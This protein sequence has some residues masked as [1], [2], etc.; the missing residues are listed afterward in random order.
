MDRGI[1]MIF[2]AVTWVMLVLASCTTA[3]L[4]AGDLSP[5]LPADTHFV[6]TA[7][8]M[9]VL[10][11]AWANSSL[12]KLIQGADMQP[13]RAALDADNVA[14]LIRLRPWF[15]WD[16]AELAEVPDQVT[17]GIFPSAIP[18]AA[19]PAPAKAP[20]AK[21]PPAKGAAPAAPTQQAE[22][23]CLIAKGKDP[24]AAAACRTAGEAYFKNLGIA[25]V[26]KQAGK[27]AVT[28]YTFKPKVGADYT[29]V[30][31]ETPQYLGAAT[32]LRGAELVLAKLA[33]APAANPAP[34]KGLASF[35]LEPLPLFKLLSKPPAKGKRNMVRFFERQGGGEIELVSG[36]LELPEKG[37]LELALQGEL[38]GNFPLPKGLGILDYKLGAPAN[39]DDYFGKT[40]H[41]VRHWR[42]DFPKAMKSLGNL[43]DEWTEPGPS[44]EGV[45]D[46]LLDGLRDDP[47]GQKID[48]RKDLFAQLGP[49]VTELKIDDPAAKVPPVQYKLD[50]IECIDAVKAEATLK[51]YWDDP[52]VMQDVKNG[53]VIYYVKPGDSLFVGG[54]KGK[55]NQQSQNIEA[56]TFRGK[57]LYLCD[58]YPALLEYFAA[59]AKAADP[60]T[61]A[62]LVATYKAAQT[63]GGDQLGYVGLALSEQSWQVPYTRLQAP[64]IPDEPANIGLLRGALF[65]KE[66]ARPAGIEKTLPPW[67]KV[68]PLAAPTFNLLKPDGKGM[69]WNYGIVR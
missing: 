12:G 43:F 59:Q 22:F 42:W 10:G 41:T 62:R 17:F 68:Q 48:M 11:T 69:L 19:N 21:A 6:A 8:E 4:Q 33:A 23:V 54:R 55:K 37:E 27:I 60:K 50:I 28:S 32:S 16:W 5:L 49:S 67:N 34:A 14:C 35:A 45:F 31:F 7:P 44:G 9:K 66:E 40:A 2:R 13:Y 53:P 61:T 63:V 57:M 3:T 26:N 46:D 29:T 52:A 36:S 15:G 56:A 38:Q 25:P 39:L 1:R 18:A 64:A 58:S 51:K 20:P 30:Y 65:G 24:K 47:M